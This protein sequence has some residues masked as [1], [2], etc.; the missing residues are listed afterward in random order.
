M[1]SYADPQEEIRGTIVIHNNIL[2][3]LVIGDLHINPPVIQGGMGVAVSSSRLAAA[4]SREG[5]LGVIA[6]VGA[7]ESCP[8]GD[9]SYK[10]RS[11]RGLRKILQDAGALT[12]RPVGVNI[13]CALSDYDEL[14]HAA[15]DG[16]AAVIISGAG[17]PLHLPEL[18]GDAPVKLIPVV[19][20]AHAASIICRVWWKKYRRVPDALVVE[21][22]AA[23]GHLGFSL[24]EVS[25]HPSLP[26]IVAEVMDEV[27]PFEEM[28]RRRIPVIA[29]GGIYSGAD[30]AHFLKLGAAG[31]QMGTRFVCT[32][33]C[34]ASHAYKTAYLECRK[35]DI[36][37][38]RSPVGLPLRVIRNSFVDG[39]LSSPKK[40]FACT[41]HCLRNCIP[42]KSSYCIARA[43]ANAVKGE[44]SEGIITCGSNTYRI[45]EIVSVHELIAELT[46]E[47]R[48]ELDS[49]SDGAAEI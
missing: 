19:S 46:E 5:A 15:V 36:V 37:I 17:L 16:N 3:D 21:G 29:A 2:P 49:G 10:E 24:E 12:D 40:Q 45:E 9:L 41:Y 28:H 20:S 39:L 44:L 23:G 13:M 33:E 30:I 35:E 22:A 43:L 25:R 8:R 6:A 18:T 31:V 38:I 32:D 27:R 7:S 4:V 42:A 48:R 26:A 1:R 34:D 47:C 11:Y 14:V